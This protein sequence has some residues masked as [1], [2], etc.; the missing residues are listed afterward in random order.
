MTRYIRCDK[1][2]SGGGQE[3]THTYTKHSC[4]HTHTRRSRTY[5]THP[6]LSEIFHFRATAAHTHT[7]TQLA[8]TYTHLTCTHTQARAH[9]SAHTH[10]HKQT[11][12]HTATAPHIH[13]N[14]QKCVFCSAEG[15]RNSREALT[16][17]KGPHGTLRGL[18]SGSQCR[19]IKDAPH[20]N[21]SF[22]E[23]EF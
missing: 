22:K 20:R 8:C 17:A 21:L 6:F 1:A 9:T 12:T 5:Y 23:T 15:Q 3:S 7:Q 4:V 18:G 13:S 14:S 19:D 2:S 16:D 10:P 11:H